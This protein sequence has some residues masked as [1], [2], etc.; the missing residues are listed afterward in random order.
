MLIK[1]F[2]AMS[3]EL[4]FF[5]ILRLTLIKFLWYGWFKNHYH[6]AR[7][8]HSSSS[9]CC[10]NSCWLKLKTPRKYPPHVLVSQPTIANHFT[11]PAFENLSII[12]KCYLSVCLP[13]VVFSVLRI[14]RAVYSVYSTP[15]VQQ[16]ILLFSRKI[17]RSEYWSVVLGYCLSAN[18]WTWQ[19][20]IVCISYGFFSIYFLTISIFL[21]QEVLL[22][23][24][25]NLKDQAL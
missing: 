9:R 25:K 19:V 21:R 17:H 18:E 1:R 11:H 6:K 20:C 3:I 2:Q 15:P 14:I 16:K 12:K 8:K 7:E 13:F 4:N 22:L 23:H 10:Q 24:G 5:F